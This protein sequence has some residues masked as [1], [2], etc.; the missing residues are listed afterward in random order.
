MDVRGQAGTAVSSFVERHNAFRDDGTA[1]V[2]ISDDSLEGKKATIVITD[3]DGVL[4]CQKNTT[5]GGE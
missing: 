2:V 5:I 1:S 4:I 3:K